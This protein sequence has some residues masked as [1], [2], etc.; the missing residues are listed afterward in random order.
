MQ[1]YLDHAIFWDFLTTIIIG[2]AL[3]FGQPILEGLFIHSTIESL[4]GFGSSLITV[5]ATLVGFLLTIITVIVT[6]KK[7]FEDKITEEPNLETVTKI[8]EK[9]VFEKNISKEEK[10]YST[11]IHKRVVEVFVNATYE[12]GSVLF[13]LLTIQLKIFNFSVYWILI[14]SFCVFILMMLST[15]RSLY[16]FKLFLKVH[17]KH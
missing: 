10:F 5:S 12:I 3:F 2:V 16:I 4:I 11:P 14:I 13:I 1:K 6:F 7:G 9:T 17:L 15:I 8:P